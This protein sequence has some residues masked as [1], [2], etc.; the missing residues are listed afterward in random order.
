MPARV[1]TEIGGHDGRI[2]DHAAHGEAF[3]HEP[4]ARLLV[5]SLV[6]GGNLDTDKGRG[7]PLAGGIGKPI[8][9]EKA[10][11]RALE[12][13]IRH[14]LAKDR[15]GDKFGV[16]FPFQDI[17][18]DGP[19]IVGGIRLR[20]RGAETIKQRQKM[21][22]IGLLVAV[23]GLL[24]GLERQIGRPAGRGQ[25]RKGARVQ[26]VGQHITLLHHWLS[27]G[28]S[29]QSRFYLLSLDP[30]IEWVEIIM[31]SQLSLYSL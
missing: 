23:G 27:I 3:G 24:R 30:Q 26:L 10:E 2:I 20:M 11:G 4:V 14:A 16:A 22:Q 7:D 31:A 1:D 28:T 13:L 19:E 5:D 9:G 21:P 25:R 8:L 6:G 15:V 18:P 12:G 17:F 29:A